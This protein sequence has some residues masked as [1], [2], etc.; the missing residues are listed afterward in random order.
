MLIDVDDSF[1]PNA[2]AAND[3][4]NPKVV[5]WE[6]LMETYQDTEQS[7]DPGGKW[8]PATCI[9]DLSDHTG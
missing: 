1:D 2:K 4:S 3:A 5:E 6:R 9:F 7:G 8:K